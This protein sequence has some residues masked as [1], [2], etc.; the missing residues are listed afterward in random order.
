MT[1]QKIETGYSAIDRH[2]GA[3]NGLNRGLICRV[4]GVCSLFLFS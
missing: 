4:K 3:K 1:V 2:K